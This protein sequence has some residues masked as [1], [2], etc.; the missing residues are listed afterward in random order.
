MYKMIYYNKDGPIIRSMVEYD[1][2]KLVKGFLEQ[3]WH[4]SYELFIQYY[5]PY[6]LFSQNEK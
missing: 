1:I 4:K 6:K 5:I 2:E 3:G